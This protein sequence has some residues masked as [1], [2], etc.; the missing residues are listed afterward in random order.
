MPKLAYLS[1]LL[2]LGERG[3]GL[4]FEPLHGGTFSYERP[5]P[6]PKKPEA[7]C[8]TRVIRK[9]TIKRL[10]ALEAAT[11]LSSQAQSFSPDFL[12]SVADYVASFQP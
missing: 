9:M 10:L 2:V 7:Q 5:L 3:P 1:F 4:A 6:T 8:S 11:R 12:Y